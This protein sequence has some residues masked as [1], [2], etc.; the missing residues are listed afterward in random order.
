MGIIIGSSIGAAVLLIATVAS[1]L[2]MHKGKKRYY[3]QGMPVK[4]LEVY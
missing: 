3:D 1:C 4:N 2:Y